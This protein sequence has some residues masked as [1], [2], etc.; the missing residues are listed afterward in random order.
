MRQVL[1]NA[2]DPAPL[3]TAPEYVELLNALQKA[4]ETEDTRR[5]LAI[6]Q[7]IRAMV[8]PGFYTGYLDDV[9]TRVSVCKVLT[10]QRLSGSANLHAFYL[11]L[12]EFKD[13]H[14]VGAMRRME[15]ADFLRDIRRDGGAERQH[16]GRRFWV[17]DN[18]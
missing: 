10:I 12:Q 18:S 11:E 5:A 17:S 2:S 14:P 8:P 13:G 7:R 15:L 6:D 1:K 4:Q 16:V 9:G 3:P